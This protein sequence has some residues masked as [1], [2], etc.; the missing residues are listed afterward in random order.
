[1]LSTWFWQGG[2]QTIA[3]K[4]ANTML[5]ADR[6]APV[7][8]SS[9]CAS[10]SIFDRKVKELQRN[11]AGKQPDSSVYDY[12]KEEVGWR[13]ADRVFDIK[14]QFDTILDLGCGKGY[15]FKHFDKDMVRHVV[16][17]ELSDALL[18]ATEPPE[19]VQLSRRHE[20]EETLQLDENSV[21]LVTSS[22]S[23]HWVND[24][25]G[26]F[27][28]V[29]RCL[30][31]DGAFVGAVLGG[32]TLYQLRCALQL[33]SLEREGGVGLHV[34]PFVKA[35]DV[36]GLLTRAGFTMLTIDVD[37]VTVGYPS[38]FELMWDLQGMAENNAA[39]N[40]KL[41]L[42]RDTMMAAAAVYQEM[43]GSSPEKDDG[44]VPATFEVLHFI[45]WKPGAGQP[46]PLDRG[47]G[48]VS[49]RDLGSVVSGS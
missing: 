41:R 24:L 37:S 43:Y 1:M 6:L 15:V 31:P 21:D 23:L 32:D 11:Y 34:S 27:G 20:D 30:R 40:R 39:Y 38:M 28:R 42:N 14:R 36:G 47:S 17:C 16:A 18:A 33:A 10:A 29:H 4:L 9:K 13:V 19:G 49:L 5:K 25:P 7:S 12:V 48:T 35:Q 44:S 22:L 45:A 26:C 3:R 2:L 46:Q 8:T